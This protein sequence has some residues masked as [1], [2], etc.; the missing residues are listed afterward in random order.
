MEYKF[1]DGRWMTNDAKLPI[2]V[3]SSVYSVCI[4]PHPSPF[5]L[6]LGLPLRGRHH[7]ESDVK[8]E[9]VTDKPATNGTSMWFVTPDSHCR[10]RTRAITKC[11]R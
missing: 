2:V 8:R 11:S 7:P 5:Y 3:L 6:S 10:R 9:L 4:P 1:V